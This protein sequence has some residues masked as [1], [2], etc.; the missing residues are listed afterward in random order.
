MGQWAHPRTRASSLLEANVE[1]VRA[2]PIT[3]FLR[4]TAV[5]RRGLVGDATG[6]P[7]RPATS[8]V[9][10]AGRSHLLQAFTGA[11]SFDPF[12]LGHSMVRDIG[13]HRHHAQCSRHWRHASSCQNC[14]MLPDDAATP[15]EWINNLCRIV[16]AVHQWAWGLLAVSTCLSSQRTRQTLDNA[17]RLR[18]PQCKFTARRGVHGTAACCIVT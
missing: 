11:G 1:S 6:S 17:S 13:I 10:P 18:S 15:M 14:R 8:P 4:A 16:L 3:R 7:S 9:P 12:N 5:E 2:R